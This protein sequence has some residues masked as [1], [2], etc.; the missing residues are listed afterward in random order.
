MLICI[1]S[2]TLIFALNQTK[3][4]AVQV[5]RWVGQSLE[6]VIP[7]LVAQEVTRNLGTP[8][9]I[10]QFYHLF[11]NNRVAQIVDEPVP[12]EL[13]KKYIDFGLP[14]KADAFIGA[15]AEWQNVSYLISE[16]RHFLRD[17][18]TPAFKVRSS[19]QFLKDFEISNV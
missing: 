6:L 5:W 19:A 9:Q 15:F 2:S 18:S 1:D 13:V 7:R 17:L 14:E 12:A 11:K 8:A 4:S 10:R 16:N 3:P